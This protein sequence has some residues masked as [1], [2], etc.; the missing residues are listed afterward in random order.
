MRVTWLSY[1][2]VP[3]ASSFARL[4][5]HVT[6]RYFPFFFSSCSK[7]RPGTKNGQTIRSHLRSLLW[8]RSDTDSILFTT[9]YNSQEKGGWNV[10]AKG[11][12]DRKKLE[13]KAYPHMN[14]ESHKVR[15]KERNKRFFREELIKS[16]DF[17]LF[18]MQ[19]IDIFMKSMYMHARSSNLHNRSQI[20]NLLIQT[21]SSH[22]N[23]SKMR[24]VSFA[25]TSIINFITWTIVSDT[26]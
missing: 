17:T 2:R 15:N 22:R 21:T 5:L 10:S 19:L 8:G 12:L 13:R 1:L 11:Q 4:R 7:K 14:R 25:R 26:Q 6:R 23:L 9:L 24:C 3:V 20:F 16:K 18:N